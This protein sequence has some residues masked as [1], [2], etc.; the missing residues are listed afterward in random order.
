MKRKTRVLVLTSS[1]PRSKNDWWAQFIFHIYEH[2]SQD[3]DI[4]LL[5]PDASGSKKNEKFGPIDVHRFSY[6]YPRSLQVLTTGTGILHSSK[7]NLFARLQIPLFIIS[8][9]IHS[10]VY[11]IQYKPDIFHA[12]W[13]IPQGLIGVFIKKLFSIPLVVTV[14]GSDIFGLKRLKFLKQFVL[15]NCDMCTVNSSYTRNA[16]LQIY[17]ATPIS[18]I[19]MGV[20]T[21]QFSPKR[22]SAVTR[23]ELSK[24]GGPILLCVGRLIG[25]KGFEY[26]IRSLPT[27]LTQFSDTMLVIVGDGP[28]RGELVNLSKELNVYNHMKFVQS[29]PHEKLSAIYASSDICLVPSIIDPE[30]GETESQ[31]IVPVETM[32]SGIPVIATDCGGLSDAVISG[33]TGFIVPKK[34]SDAIAKHAIVLLSDKV[35]L[36]KMGKNG[37]RIANINY[38]WEKITSQFEALYMRIAG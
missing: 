18:I 2:I 6:C 31:G 38:S 21:K 29:I 33:E 12:H 26:A 8:A 5:G 36:K 14:H 17:F 9:A 3:Y 32:A 13:L 15:K 24:K 25:V 27:I 37:V 23:K 22:K 11:T 34:D 4:T 16:V 30:T 1:F 28:K 19:P 10:A 20:D 35:L 7:T